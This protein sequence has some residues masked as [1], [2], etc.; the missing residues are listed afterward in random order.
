TIK[1]H[2]RHANHKALHSINQQ[3]D[4]LSPEVVSAVK[5]FAGRDLRTID[6][7]HD[8]RNLKQVIDNDKN[9]ATI[10]LACLIVKSYYQQSHQVSNKIHLLTIVSQFFGI[11]QKITNSLIKKAQKGEDVFLDFINQHQQPLEEVLQKTVLDNIL[12]DKHH[13]VI[14]A[15]DKT[16][17]INEYA[18]SGASSSIL[19]PINNICNWLKE[20]IIELASHILKLPNI[21]P[22]TA[23]NTIPECNDDY[24]YYIQESLA[25]ADTSEKKIPVITEK[26]MDDEY[27]DAL[28][29][30]PQIIKAINSNTSEIIPANYPKTRLQITPG[31]GSKAMLVNDEI[32]N[33]CGYHNNNNTP[34]LLLS[35]G[36]NN[37]TQFIQD[38]KWCESLMLAEVITRS[39]TG[40]KYRQTILLSPIQERAI[41]IYQI[42]QK[43]HAG[44]QKMTALFGDY[45]SEDQDNQDIAQ[46]FYFEDLDDDYNVYLDGDQ[47]IQDIKYL[48][49]S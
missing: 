23:A 8:L 42:E 38:L 22:T 18:T 15:A 13:H 36:E 16:L 2:I 9:Q 29:T 34:K 6:D 3:L 24:T 17:E 28:E 43:V 44:L 14:R 5:Y 48:F 40:E 37:N 1:D 25:E 12:N 26:I 11:E 47:Y 30:L 20:G 49:H 41:E 35:H 39:I 7:I 10:A 19:S 27:Y 45:D 32:I 46:Q 33:Y 31:V 4:K 21:L